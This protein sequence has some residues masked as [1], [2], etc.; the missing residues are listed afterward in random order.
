MSRIVLGSILATDYRQI[1]NSLTRFGS[2]PYYKLA[3]GLILIA[4]IV[5]TEFVVS[6]ELFRF[7]M[8][9]QY[10]EELRYVLLAKLLY[11]V[12]LIFFALLTYSNTVLSISAFFLSPELD[13]L[14]ARP[15]SSGTLF[16]K[17]L[18]ETFLGAS[19]MFV[20]FGI[21]IFVAYGYVLG[22]GLSFV[23]GLLLIVLWILLIPSGIGV[24]IGIT[25][26]SIFSPRRTQRVLMIIGVVLAVGLVI[27]FRWMRPEQLID[28]IGVEQMAVYLETLRMP[29]IDWLPTAWAS[30]GI[31]SM[32]ENRYGHVV[33]EVIRLAIVAVL[34]ILVARVVFQLLW[35]RAR[36]GGQGGLHTR[37]GSST[38]RAGKP[39]R[40]KMTLVYRDFMI[41]V[42]DPGQWTQMVVVAALFAIYVFNFKNLPYALYGFSHAMTYIA[43]A[44]SGLIQAALLARFAFPAISTEGPGMERLRSTPISWTKYFLIKYVQHVIPAGLFGV[45]LV[46]FS[47]II[48]DIQ[49]TFFVRSIVLMIEISLASTALA[50]MIGARF[51]RFDLV[52]AAQVAV[53]TGGFI[54]MFAALSTIVLMTFISAVPDLIRYF[55]FYTPRMYPILKQFDGIGSIVASAL[56]SFIVSLASIR[57]GLLTMKKVRTDHFGA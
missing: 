2:A 49:G 41:F 12:F 28:P 8:K 43:I 24:S 18:V 54:Y 33:P 11:M 42:R 44:A 15:V 46:V 17:G 56:L 55:S 30:E 13:V 47:M 40:F 36:S 5:I 3:I 4:C 27:L 6:T 16:W 19:W 51:P 9:Q 52:D 23:T 22:Q 53:S 57:Y 1:R 10:L 31:A 34:T 48:L 45:F 32:G 26:I 35:W 7:I 37:K 25:L 39:T 38:I 14:H 29:T 20:A 21:P 50:L